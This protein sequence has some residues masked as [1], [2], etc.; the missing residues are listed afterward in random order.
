VVG[1]SGI[2]FN[3]FVPVNN[4]V[5]HKNAISRTKTL[6]FIGVMVLGQLVF[7]VDGVL[8]SGGGKSSKTFSTIKK[9]LQFSLKSGYTLQGVHSSKGKGIR[10]GMYNTVVSFQKGNVT[11]YLPY[12]TKPVLSRFKTPSAPV[13]R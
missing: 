5:Y 13:I 9:D 3:I 12:K 2:I 10:Q 1:Y 7:A 11:Y 6:I 8:T 4:L